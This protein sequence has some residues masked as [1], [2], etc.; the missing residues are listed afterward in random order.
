VHLEWLRATPQPL[1][2]FEKPLP[3]IVE[4]PPDYGGLQV[5]DVRDL[6]D[7]LIDDFFQHEQGAF[8]IGERPY[9]PEEN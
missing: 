3:R 1:R 2:W 4:P 8:F 6:L 5:H 7:C 9:V